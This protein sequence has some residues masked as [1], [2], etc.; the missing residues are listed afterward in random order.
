MLPCVICD[1]LNCSHIDLPDEMFEEQLLMKIKKSDGYYPCDRSNTPTECDAFD[2]TVAINKALNI[3]GHA[4]DWSKILV[5]VPLLD[6]DLSDDEIDD[7]IKGLWPGG[8]I[9]GFDDDPT[10]PG[11]STGPTSLPVSEPIEVIRKRDGLC[12][13]CGDRGEFVGGGCM[14][15]NGHG[16]IFG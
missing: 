9:D 13:Q 15:K 10:Q 2:W 12:I 3:R 5:G 7:Y 14:C 11:V 8:N 6:I 1:A 16:K 4:V